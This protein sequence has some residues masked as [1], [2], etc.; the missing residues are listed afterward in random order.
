LLRGKSRKS[1]VSVPKFFV[2]ATIGDARLLCQIGVLEEPSCTALVWF[3][4]ALVRNRLDAGT[5]AN[6]AFAAI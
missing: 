5:Q 2:P 3:G 1:F 6:L 4:Q